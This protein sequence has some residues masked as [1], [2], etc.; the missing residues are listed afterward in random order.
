MSIRLRPILE[1]TPVDKGWKRNLRK[2]LFVISPR[3]H[4]KRA[5]RPSLRHDTCPY[6]RLAAPWRPIWLSV[7]SNHLTL[8]WQRQRDAGSKAQFH[9]VGQSS[10][11]RF[12]ASIGTEVTRFSTGKLL[13]PALVSAMMLP[14]RKRAV[15]VVPHISNAIFTDRQLTALRFLDWLG[16]VTHYDDGM[17]YASQGGILW[18]A[19]VL[20]KSPDLLITWDYRFVSRRSN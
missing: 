15:I 8:G 7:N 9:H 4:A 18:H 11:E 19:G 13:M 3:A 2:L 1:K 20:T 17:T 16:L 12:A 10:V 6:E 14:F 5:W